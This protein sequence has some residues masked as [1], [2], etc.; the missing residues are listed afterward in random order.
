MDIKF[1]THQECSAELLEKICTLKKQHW[2]YPVAEQIRWFNENLIDEDIHVC[3]FNGDDLIAYTTIV[4]IKYL[5]EDNTE[6][7]ALGIGSVCVDVKYL[8]QKYG[9]FVV[10]IV[11]AY[12]RQRGVMGILLCKDEL[13]LFYEKNNWIKFNGQIKIFDLNKA[14]N[15]LTTETIDSNIISLN[16]SF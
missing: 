1:I 4:N 8:N 14:C 11:T 9:F 5:T 16:K 12:I 10:Q 7:E 15:V 6:K 3:V 13:V 2:D